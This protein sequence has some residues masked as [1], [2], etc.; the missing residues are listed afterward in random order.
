MDGVIR[1]MLKLVEHHG[2]SGCD[3][4]SNTPVIALKE[5]IAKGLLGLK[6]GEQSTLELPSGS[7][8]IQVLGIETPEMA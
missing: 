1:S 8:D 6:P 3:G 4:N 7:L 5:A 2:K